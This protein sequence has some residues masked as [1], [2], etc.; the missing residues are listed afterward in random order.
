MASQPRGSERIHSYIQIK[1]RA[2]KS[3][4]LFNFRRI[5]LTPWDANSGATDPKNGKYEARSEDR[6]NAKDRY[7]RER[8]EDTRYHP[9]QIKWGKEGA[10]TKT[11]KTL[12]ANFN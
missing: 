12:S 6:N 4:E 1:N 8:Q 10:H 5:R 7:V 11:Q 3:A 2:D 9:W